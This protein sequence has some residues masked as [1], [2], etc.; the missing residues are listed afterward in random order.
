M[1]RTKQRRAERRAAEDS[2]GLE[3]ELGAKKERRNA[4]CMSK[5]ETQM[6][7]ATTSRHEEKKKEQE[8][9]TQRHLSEN[10]WKAHGKNRTG[11]ETTE[12]TPEQGAY[13]HRGRE[14]S[15]R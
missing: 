11:T 12:R 5:R 3:R 2:A 14:E 10:T 1:R 4:D 9:E 6:P 15:A 13:S 8:D 7:R